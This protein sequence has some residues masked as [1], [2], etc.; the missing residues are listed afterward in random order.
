MLRTKLSQ[1]TKDAMRAKD[2]AAISTLR[3]ISAAIKDRDIAARTDGVTDGVNDD[4]ILL[5]LQKM[6]KQRQESIRMY[7]EGGRLELAQQERDEIRII[8]GFLPK[9]LS[10][11]E[12]ADAVDTIIGEISASGMKDMGPLM[13][14]LRERYAGVMDFGKASAIAKSRFN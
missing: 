1:I 11:S 8:E 9:Q 13:A 5:L 14:G 2:Q 12:I 7:E 4:E 3:L 6:I 10:E